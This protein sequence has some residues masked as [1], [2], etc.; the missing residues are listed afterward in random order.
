MFKRKW[1]YLFS[2]AA[3]GFAKG[4]ITNHMLTFIR[5]VRTPF[6]CGEKY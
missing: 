6:L 2:Y 4:Y 5:E 3:A 1:E